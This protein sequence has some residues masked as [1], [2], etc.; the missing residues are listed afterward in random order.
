MVEGFSDESLTIAT[1]WLRD[2]QLRGE[3]VRGNA[4][5]CIALLA[6]LLSRR[7]LRAQIIGGRVALRLAVRGG[8]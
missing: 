7:N 6:W 5:K 4:L 1:G 3:G 8:W 2:F